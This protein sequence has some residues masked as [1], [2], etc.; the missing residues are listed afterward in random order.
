M[1]PL[2]AVE[3]AAAVRAGRLTAREAVAA[4]FERLERHDP[5]LNAF[6]VVR[7]DEALAEARAVDAGGAGR[8]GPLAGVPVAVKEEYDVVGTVT[9][10]GGRGNSTLATS[11]SEVVRR[12]RTAGAVIV[13]K[14]TMPE[15]GQVPITESEATGVTRNPWSLAHGPG[16][17]SGGSA[18]AVAAGIV[19]LALGADGGGSI[20]L[21]AAAC[22]LVGLKPTR[23]RISLAPLAQHW[24]ALVTLGGLTRTVRDSALLLDV[25]A[26]SMAGDRWRLPPPEQPF[27]AAVDREPGRLRI[28]WSTRPVQPGV[29]THPEVARATAAVA[30]RLDALGH[31][32][33]EGAP[34]WPLVQDAFIPQFFAGMREEA[35]QVDHPERLERRTRETVRLGGWVTPA[36]V[37]RA[38]RRGEELASVVDERVLASA[39]VVMVP[40]VPGLV[41]DADALGRRGGVRTMLTSLPLVT[42]ATLANVTGHPAISVPAGLDSR[43]VPS[44]SSSSP[45]GAGRTSCCP[46]RRS[47]SA[48]RPGRS[49]RWR[50]PTDPPW[51]RG[52]V[53]RWLSD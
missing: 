53:Q 25:V 23:G 27:E 46:S 40:T 49:A 17:S 9:T 36:L 15:F 24:Y 33:R 4:A 41:P 38:L 34:R 51:P 45:A 7:G 6:T 13:G 30:D 29:R 44:G 3:T 20:R 2:T 5:A 43:G 26:G 19:P 16:G 32:V 11:D 35:G 31:D 39:D 48:W 47:W 28:G 52:T 21:P 8:G 14:T 37:E 42:N 18:A 12:L 50:E 10:L 22:G 1:P